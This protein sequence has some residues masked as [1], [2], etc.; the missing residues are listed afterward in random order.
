MNGRQTVIVSS[1]RK[2]I[3]ERNLPGSGRTYFSYVCKGFPVQRKILAQCY[4]CHS[5]LQ[6]MRWPSSSLPKSGASSLT[7]SEMHITTKIT[8]G[9]IA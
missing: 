1:P 7:G 5:A 8:I 6:E 4:H 9:Y 3:L 2:M